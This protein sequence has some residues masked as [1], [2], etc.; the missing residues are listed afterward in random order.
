VNGVLDTDTTTT[1]TTTATTT[2]NGFLFFFGREGRRMER[3]RCML[4]PVY[5]PEYSKQFYCCEY[6]A[7]CV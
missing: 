6:D 1:T 3:G 7:M 5:D 4:C 2:N